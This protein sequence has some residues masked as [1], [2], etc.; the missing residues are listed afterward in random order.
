MVHITKLR[1][2]EQY[3]NTKMV[4]HRALQS[5]AGVK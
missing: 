3:N 4:S 2:I 5:T 1:L